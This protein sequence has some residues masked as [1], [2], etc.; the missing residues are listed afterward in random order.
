[1]FVETS[2]QFSSF[3]VGEVNQQFNGHDNHDLGSNGIPLKDFFNWDNNKTVLVRRT[4]AKH[5]A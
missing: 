2:E 5:V 3:A 1:M 4:E